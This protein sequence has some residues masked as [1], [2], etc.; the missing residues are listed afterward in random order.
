MCVSYRYGSGADLPGIDAL[1]LDTFDRSAPM[2][3]GYSKLGGNYAPVFRQSAMAKEAGFPITLH[4]D[5]YIDEFSTSNALALK[6]DEAKS[7][8]AASK[9]NVT[10]VVPESISILRSVTKLSIVDIAEKTLGWNVEVRKVSFDEV[11]DGS[12]QEFMAAGTAAV[13]RP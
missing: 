12:F 4:L 9:S 1:I 5:K 3:T 2:G 10:L 13:S 8:G 6:V 11:K 7:N